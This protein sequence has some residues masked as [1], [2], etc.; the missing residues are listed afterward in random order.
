MPTATQTTTY[1]VTVY[2]G[3][4]EN[5]G[6]DADVFITLFGKNGISSGERMIDNAEDNYEKGKV[7]VFQLELQQLGDLE[8]IRIR[9]DNSG[10]YPG[11]FL[12][13]IVID[14][15]GK[16]WTFPANRWFAYSSAPHSIDAVLPVAK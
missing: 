13:K 6:T 2:T 14:G 5:A 3:N 1:R 12:D 4:I 7:D 9:H 15:E 16:Q 8:A 11:W 10:S